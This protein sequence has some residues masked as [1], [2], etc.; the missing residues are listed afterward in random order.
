MSQVEVDAARRVLA[1]HGIADPLKDAV[2]VRCPESALSDKCGV[3][4][5]DTKGR[6]SCVSDLGEG[7]CPVCRGLGWIRIS[8]NDLSWLRPA[9]EKEAT[10]G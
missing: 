4:F 10:S 1:K 5:F 7:G 3:P 6:E 9:P 2:V 8:V